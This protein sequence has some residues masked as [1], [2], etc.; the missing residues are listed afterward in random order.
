MPTYSSFAH[1]TLPP[2]LGASSSNE[3]K[4]AQM[5]ALTI[6][7]ENSTPPGRV[8]RCRPM[9]ARARQMRAAP[10]SASA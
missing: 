4:S 9:P 5:A 2:K 8:L 6:I 7:A 1:V 3:Y 10:I